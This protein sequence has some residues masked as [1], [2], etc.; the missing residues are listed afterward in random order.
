LIVEKKIV[1]MV[2]LTKLL[3]SDTNQAK[4]KLFCI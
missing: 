1:E 4:C 2:S 3:P